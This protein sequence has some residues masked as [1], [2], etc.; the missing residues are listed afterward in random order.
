M[1]LRREF[2]ERKLHLI[3]E[4]LGRPAEFRDVSLEAAYVDN[5]VAFLGPPEESQP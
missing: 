5:S 4:D 3:A 2:V 1:P